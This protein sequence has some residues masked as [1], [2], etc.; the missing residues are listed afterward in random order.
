MGSSAP[1][2]RLASFWAP[3]IG[4]DW[5]ALAFFLLAIEANVAT[6]SASAKLP[7]DLDDEEDE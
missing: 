4:T 7:Q 1:Q 5:F 2:F 3:E 6:M